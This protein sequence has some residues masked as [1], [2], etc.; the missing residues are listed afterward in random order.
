MTDRGR[1]QAARG[2][3]AHLGVP[4]EA[5]APAGTRFL[6]RPGA[7][8]VVA[9]RLGTGVLVVAPPA[10]VALLEHLPDE[11]LTDDAA[12]VT[13]LARLGPRPLG[14]ATLSYRGAPPPVPQ[15]P[16]APADD[17]AVA[18]VAAGCAAGEWDESGL[19][20]MP[21]RWVAL[22]DDGTSAAVAGYERWGPDVA[23]VG[24]AAAAS[25]RGQGLARAA[26]AATVASA[27]AEGLVAQWRCRVGNTASERLAARLGFTP[28]GRQAAV[29][30]D[31]S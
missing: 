14:T 27:V 9:L 3:A 20:G 25:H 10:A 7:T 12:L 22:A 19:A 16:V 8:A 11:A 2:W 13:A 21:H 23:Q 28:L 31:R 24:V 30:L 6:R 5:L 29:L 1:A 15:L 4:V 18:A 17:E 26:G